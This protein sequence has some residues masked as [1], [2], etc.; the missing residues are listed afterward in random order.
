[1]KTCTQCNEPIQPHHAFCPNCG[2]ESKS[3]KSINKSSKRTKNTIALN[4][5]TQKN[6]RYP[7]VIGVSVIVIIAGI[8]WISQSLS[9]YFQ[10]Q[11]VTTSVK[12]SST[13]FPDA[14]I[15]LDTDMYQ[16]ASYFYC[17][18]GDCQDPELVTCG[19]PTARSQREFIQKQLDEGKTVIETRTLVSQ[20]Y[21]KLKPE[22][23]DSLESK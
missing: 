10:G 3:S 23:Q 2:K 21:G 12:H 16:V 13:N 22:Y 15:S 14:Q 17:S 9:Q 5:S 6:S 20:M 7:I 18:C 11:L 8:Y 19:C 4:D 1:M